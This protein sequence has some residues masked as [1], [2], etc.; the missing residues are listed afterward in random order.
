MSCLSLFKYTKFSS[1]INPIRY[2]NKKILNKTIISKM[3]FKHTSSVITII[4]Y[5]YV[6]KNKLNNIKISINNIYNLFIYNKKNV[7]DFLYK[8]LYLNKK[9]DFKIIILRKPFYNSSILVK[10]ISNILMKERAR[11]MRI[12]NK[13][14][15]A[16]KLSY[17]NKLS[18]SKDIIYKNILSNITS[19]N[20]LPYVG[21][22]KLNTNFFSIPNKLK[23]VLK[24]IQFKFLNGLTLTMNGRLTKRRTASR[25]LNKFFHKGDLRN[26]HSSCK[27]SSVKV[28]RN[29][30]N[31]NIDAFLSQG[32]T[33]NGSFIVKIKISGY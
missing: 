14:F 22:H 11:Y 3:Q 20:I 21:I 29:S 1:Y 6:K 16:F 13:L 33:K 25:A 28:Q 32:K 15:E 27:S 19:L 24:T 5:I 12:K 10:Y 18:Y 7:E 4:I 31:S 26:I 9:I 30:I 2:F 23:L 8:Y 17:S